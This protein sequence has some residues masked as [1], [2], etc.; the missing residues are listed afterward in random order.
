MALHRPQKPSKPHQP[1]T[2]LLPLNS[3]RKSLQ[4]LLIRAAMVEFCSARRPRPHHRPFLM[5]FRLDRRQF[6]SGTVTLLLQG[7]RQASISTR[8][9]GEERLTRAHLRAVALVSA[10]VALERRVLATS[11]RSRRC[12]LTSSPCWA[13]SSGFRPRLRCANGSSV[14]LG[15]LLP[16]P[17]YSVATCVECE[18]LN[19]EG[20]YCARLAD[21]TGNNFNQTGASPGQSVSQAI[22]SWRMC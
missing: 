11:P 19:N 17:C 14:R 18:W 4:I 3:R 22:V 12:R 13:R 20:L 2:P 15:Y 7:A 21:P 16:G 9:W 8:F 1:R 5:T 10:L 6:P